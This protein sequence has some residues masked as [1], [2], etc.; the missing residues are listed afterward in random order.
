M[1]TNAGGRAVRKTRTSIILT[2]ALLSAV[3][4]FGL[5]ELRGRT[6][7]AAVFVWFPDG[8][9][10]RVSP[11][12]NAIFYQPHIHPCVVFFGNESGPPRVWKA[13]LASG[14]VIALTPQAVGARHPALSWDG[15][16]IVFSSDLASGQKPEGIERMH[17]DGKPP[18][19]LVLNL[20]VMDADGLNM[21]QITF[22]PYQDQR[23]CFSPDGKTIAFVSNRGGGMGLWS[24]PADGSTAPRPL[25]SRG[26]G[27]RPCFSTGGRWIFSLLV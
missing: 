14:E 20:F 27:Y 16:R 15:S 24:V 5:L 2:L 10:Q 12:V 8:R 23:P 19:D 11:S 18:K 22:G 4:V 6:F 26:W 17:G 13:D 9:I 7:T 21:H 25:Q 1:N 3:I